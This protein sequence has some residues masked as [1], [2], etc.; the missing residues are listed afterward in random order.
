MDCKK[1]KADLLLASRTD[2]NTTLKMKN[3]MADNFDCCVDLTE[4]LLYPVSKRRLEDYAAL[5]RI[6]QI[7]TGFRVSSAEAVLIEDSLPDEDIESV[8]DMLLRAQT[9]DPKSVLG[10]TRLEM[11]GNTLN[12]TTMINFGDCSGLAAIQY[13]A[14]R[15]DRVTL[16]KLL[17]KE[18]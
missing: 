10:V 14:S 18:V 6:K 16:I 12:Y 2:L 7:P 17:N 9:R 1:W 8:R 13:R 4:S 3:W 15:Y 11:D 5:I